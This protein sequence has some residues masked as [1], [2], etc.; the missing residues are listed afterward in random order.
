M[1]KLNEQWI[2]AKAA[3][4]TRLDLKL[5]CFVDSGG[6]FSLVL[7]QY[8]A[9]IE[10][11]A[12][13]AKDGKNWPGIEVQFHKGRWCALGKE[14]DK[15]TKFV[16]AAAL[17]SISGTELHERVIVYN[18][19]TVVSFWA[20]QDGSIHPNGGSPEAGEGDWWKP[21]LGAFQLSS[22]HTT[23]LF[24]IGLCAGV[25]DKITT[26]RATGKTL[27]YEFV[28]AEHQNEEQE[29]TPSGRLNSFRGLEFNPED[30]AM[31]E[32]PYSDEAAL[33]FYD[34]MM[35]ICKLARNLDAF[36]ADDNRLKKAIATRTNFL[37]TK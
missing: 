1:A 24:S 29:S 13:L 28:K 36:F 19:S 14:L 32:M 16:H 15:L 7:D 25:F 3:D 21:G 37:L 8:E 6:K 22:L 10:S 11:A 27:R 35:T 26:T 20:N 30:A 2:S 31:K 4:D 12:Q 33:F 9:V 34:T 17:D 23:D 18:I 5:P